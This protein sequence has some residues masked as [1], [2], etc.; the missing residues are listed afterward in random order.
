MSLR[1]LITIFAMF[2]LASGCAHTHPELMTK[3]T[4]QECNP[5]PPVPKVERFEYKVVIQASDLVRQLLMQV[6][7]E[8]REVELRKRLLDTIDFLVEVKGNHPYYE[9][10]VQI[11]NRTAKCEYNTPCPLSVKLGKLDFEFIINLTNKSNSE[12]LQDRVSSLVNL[13]IGRQLTP[14]AFLTNVTLGQAN[15]TEDIRWQTEERDKNQISIT[16]ALVAELQ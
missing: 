14:E 11:S 15:G 3:Q 16:G 9:R 2:I 13:F 7:T 6:D 12:E 10:R 5:T 8:E 4:S 1:I